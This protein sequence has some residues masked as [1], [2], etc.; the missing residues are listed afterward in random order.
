[1]ENLNASAVPAGAFAAY[2]G[3]NFDWDHYFVEYQAAVESL[4]NAICQAP[5]LPDRHALPLLFLVRHTIELGY[6]WNLSELYLIVGP[7][8]L[9]VTH[10][11]AALHTMLG[12]ALEL[13]LKKDWV[14]E[15]IK[16]QCRHRYSEASQM[17]DWLHKLDER[18][19]AFRYPF[20]TK[21]VEEN[22]KKK[23]VTDVKRH[24]DFLKQVNL[25]KEVMEPYQQMMVFLNHT[26]DV[27]GLDEFKHQRALR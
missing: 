6:K 4:W 1:M 18:N 17:T 20:K 2:I 24:F 12:E 3:Q 27:L 19:D 22:G 11:L 5:I 8:D 14:S 21:R 9:D 23:T 15:E 10:N 26:C 13:F 25:L 7:R 16:Q